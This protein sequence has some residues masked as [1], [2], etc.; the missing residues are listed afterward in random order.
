MASC[1][2][3][4]S[5]LV[6]KQACPLCTRYAP[7]P[8]PAAPQAWQPPAAPYQPVQYTEAWTRHT[9]GGYAQVSPADIGL[10]NRRIIRASIATL[11]LAL[12][13][14]VVGMILASLS[15]NDLMR[16]ILDA[17]GLD[18]RI[19]T[20][21]GL[22]YVALGLVTL[23]RRRSYI[24]PALAL[25]IFGLDS[26]LWAL[27]SLFGLSLVA[28]LANRYGLDTAATISDAL[29]RMVVP[30]ALRALVL[31]I[32]FRGLSGVAVLKLAPS[33]EQGRPAQ[34]A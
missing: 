25:L 1:P 29:G 20:G 6:G 3:C 19:I 28:G 16:Y 22:L 18:W 11:I 32:Q 7:A 24:A 2:R 12:V 27:G 4:G 8:G 5:Y 30:F 9:P 21:I 26:L 23:F 33:A 13:N 31:Y 10:A 15:Q 34:A 17:I 14:L